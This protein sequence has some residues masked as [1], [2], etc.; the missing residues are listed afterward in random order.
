[1]GNLPL[2][3]SLAFFLSIQIA[4]A[5]TPLWR[6][7]ISLIP[8]PQQV[9]LGGVDF[10]FQGEVGVLLDPAPSPADRFAA[11]DLTARLK[12]DFGIAA[13]VGTSSAAKT[14]VLTRRAPVERVGE[15][16]Y[17]LTVDRDRLTVSANSEQGLFHGTRTLLQV[18]QEGGSG[19]FVKGMKITDWPDI[20][21]R[22][23]HYD[24]KHHQDKAEYVRELIRTLADYKINMLIWEW[25]DKFA[26]PSHPEIGA[27]GAFSM[28][29]MQ[30]FTRYARQYHI[31]LVPLVQGLGH[32][33]YILKWPQ[34]AHLRELPAS[35]W[36]FCPRKEGSYKLLFDLWG[37]AIKATPGSSYIHLGTDEAYE[38][39]QGVECGC[40]ARMKEVGRYG[41]T[42][43]F[44]D[45][46]ARH[47]ASQGRQVMSWAG[48][49]RASEKIRPPA[50][51]ITFQ[52]PAKLEVA[53]LSREAGYPVW[54]YDPNPGIEHLF[55]P[56]FYR[57]RWATERTNC[58]DDS[59]QVLSAA[60]SSGWYGGMVSTSWDASGLHYQAWIMRFIHAAEYSWNGK[61]PTH[62]E[63]IDKYFRNFYGPKA[64]GLRELWMLLNKGAYY[65]MDAFEHRVWHWGQI[66]KTHLPDL[67]RGDAVEYNPFWNARYKEMVERS[68]SQLGEMQRALD[69]CRSNLTRGVK[70]GYD[71]EVFSTVA[72]LIAHTARTYLALSALENAITEA[73]RQHFVSHQVSYAAF[74]KAAG[75]IE[76][77]VKE[78]DKVFRELVT[79][80]EKT[81]LPKGLST[82]EKKFFHQTD[83]GRNFSFRTADMTY[84]ICDEQRL[85]LE[86]YLKNL[87]AY[88]AWYKTTYRVGGRPA[89]AAS[90]PP[91]RSQT[92]S[93]V[94]RQ[95]E[96]LCTLAGSGYP[97]FT[98]GGKW[99]FV[100]PSSWVAG[101]LPGMLWLMY[102]HTKDAVWAERA[103]RWTD[104]IARNGAKGLNAGVLCMPTFV[105]GYRLT[106]DR[107][108]RQLALDAAAS[109]AGRYL[110]EGRFI[111]YGSG[112]YEGSLIIDDLID[113]VFLYWAARETGQPRLA[114][115]ATDHAVTT[116]E[117]TVRRDGSSFQA[118][119]LDPKTGK[120]IAAVPRQ[121][122][123]PESCWS[124]GQGWAIYSLP[125][126]YGYTRDDRFL[127]TAERMANWWL[128]HVPD[129]YVPY[130]DFDVPAAADTPRDS[131]AAAM[132]AGGLWELSRLVRNKQR[133]ERYRTAALKTLDSLS[134][135]Y[136]AA[137]E[138]RDNGRILVHATTWKARDLGVDESLI[139]GDYYYLELLLKV[140]K[141]LA[142]GKK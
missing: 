83:R 7:R 40:Q 85:G 129:D 114:N 25:E 60:A 123:T 132:T 37:D 53:K 141:E 125:E 86:D 45:R 78:R 88:M 55:L 2:E 120:K 84:L 109:F 43:D 124:R 62:G 107:S 133:A 73:H 54:I 36:E 137:G 42:L 82:P 111:R 121:G 9:E 31:Q 64:E 138:E 22:A 33:S 28:E 41:L 46:C 136:L 70:H 30:A 68:R 80:W 115:I 117:T 13:R 89:A 51:L 12:A 4:A 63:F 77:N 38:V 29:E 142:A 59:Y 113:L 97:E 1:M 3:V 131:S 95:L 23:V 128:D 101:Y 81:R 34:H 48:D 24:T 21:E 112:K 65:Y 11:G 20:P 94:G 61:A 139:V 127:K 91:D 135:R 96:R 71:L 116:L 57:L 119:E 39:G 110:P 102:G 92:L 98:T 108:Y 10:V 32:A 118:V 67:P 8:Y 104:P 6:E 47:L 49:Y 76:A 122:I 27:P 140:I 50:G 19:P 56:Y 44:V 17:T 100:G 126:I 130:W 5:E 93:F 14:I 58:L 52:M 134:G 15:Q 72:E 79:V 16:G 18:I 90:P 99:R 103:R 26:Y 35:N 87:R 105:A 69:I 74:E 66:G 106:G 75:N